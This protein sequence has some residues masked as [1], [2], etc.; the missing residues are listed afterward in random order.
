MLAARRR[1]DVLRLPLD[2]L[3]KR[4]VRRRVAG[5]KRND[6]IDCVGEFESLRV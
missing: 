4:L 2:A 1:Q 5:M 3:R 6:K